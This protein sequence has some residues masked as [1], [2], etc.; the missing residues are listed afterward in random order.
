MTELQASRWF[1]DLSEQDQAF[2]RR[3]VLCSGSLKEL[4]RAYDVSYPT[5]RLRLDRLIAKIEILE[6]QESLSEFER[7]LRAAYADGTVDMATFKNLL[8]AH[9]AVV[10][11][12]QEHSP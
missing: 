10:T 8:E 3:F 4:A 6:E 1:G 7:T 9:Q 11:E 2:I 5:I 12:V